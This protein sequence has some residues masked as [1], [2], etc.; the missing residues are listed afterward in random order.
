MVS[1]V[2]VAPTG[3]QGGKAAVIVRVGVTHSA[4]IKNSGGV[5]QG[6]AVGVFRLLEA[7]KKLTEAGDVCF[8]DLIVFS[9]LF[10]ESTLSLL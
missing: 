6:E 2:T 10:P 9:Y 5:K 7:A 4:A 8:A 3:E 1:A